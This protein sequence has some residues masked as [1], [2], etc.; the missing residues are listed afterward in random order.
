MT[1]AQSTTAAALDGSGETRKLAMSLQP[2]QNS[3]YRREKQTT[4]EK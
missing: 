1:A 4:P 2:P 3:N